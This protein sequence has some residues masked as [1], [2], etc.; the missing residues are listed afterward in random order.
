MTAESIA[1]SI[2]SML[3]NAKEKKMPIDNAMHADAAPG[4]QQDNW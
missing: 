2:L 3:S 4:Q 1:V